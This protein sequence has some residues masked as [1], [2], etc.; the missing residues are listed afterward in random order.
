M[1]KTLREILFSY[2]A[3]FFHS[4]IAKK[5]AENKNNNNNNNNNNNQKKYN[6]VLPL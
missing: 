2:V 3:Y 4:G 6:K 5:L 1:T